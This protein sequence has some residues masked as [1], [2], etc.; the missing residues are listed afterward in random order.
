MNRENNP[1]GASGIRKGIGLL[2]LCH[3]VAEGLLIIFGFT[4]GALQ[5]LPRL[6]WGYPLDEWILGAMLFIGATQLV[7]GLPLCIVCLYRRRFGTLK[8]VIVGMV[9]TAL[10]NGGCYL[11]LLQ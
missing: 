3:L 9:L 8:G 10:L 11:I 4:H 7:Y 1:N 5:Q 6:V 2:L